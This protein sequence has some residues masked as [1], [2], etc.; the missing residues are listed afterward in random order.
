[1]P[2]TTAKQRRF[3]RAELGRK[4]AGQAPKTQMSEAQLHDFAKAP[5]REQKQGKSKKG[6][7]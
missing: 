6:R 1:M 5:V 3:M 7:R 2:A 4:R